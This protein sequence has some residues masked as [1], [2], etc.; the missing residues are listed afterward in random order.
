[1][2][3]PPSITND[4]KCGIF[5]QVTLKGENSVIANYWHENSCHTLVAISRLGEN[6]QNENCYEVETPCHLTSYF[7]KQNKDPQGTKR[8]DI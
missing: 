5:P 2:S 3:W 8:N 4:N 6:G 7:K 1:M